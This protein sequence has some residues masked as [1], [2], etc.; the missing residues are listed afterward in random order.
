MKRKIFMLS[1]LVFALTAC[2][3]KKGTVPPGPYELAK[4]PGAEQTMQIEGI[5]IVFIDEGKGAPI[6]F[7]HGLSGD[8]SDW[9]DNIAYFKQHYRVVALDL[10]GHGKSEKRDDIR[11]GRELFT[12]VVS[13]F[14]KGRGVDRAVVIGNSM[15]GLIAASLTLAHPE[16]VGK[17]VLSDAAGVSGIA[18]YLK[19]A[20][21]LA[22]P[23][24]TRK[25]WAS[26]KTIAKTAGNAFA[27]PEN[28]P[29]ARVRNDIAMVQAPDAKNY[30]YAV[31]RSLQDTLKQNLRGDLAKI[32]CPT[33]IIWGDHDTVINPKA[34]TIWKDGIPGSKLV[35]IPETGHIPMVERPEAFNNTVE[36]F[37]NGH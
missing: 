27:H 10:P 5:R 36:T 2:A 26:P 22:T 19:W 33:L 23:G 37:I 18:F 13:E 24:M 7:I 21:A 30:S 28:Y 11:Y 17:L 15:G 34:A 29:V 25:F 4:Y 8:I 31:L 20:A 6:L 9:N 14:L 1:I 32:K 3:A 16:Q 12:R 35:F